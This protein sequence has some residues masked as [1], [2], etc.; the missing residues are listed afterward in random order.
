[1]GGTDGLFP[2]VRLHIGLCMVWTVR[3]A[4]LRYQGGIRAEYPNWMGHYFAE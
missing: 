2:R 3:F 4:Q 1:M